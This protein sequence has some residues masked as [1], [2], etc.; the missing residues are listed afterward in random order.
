MKDKEIERLNTLKEFENN[1]Y[2][3]GLKYIAGIDEAGRGPLAGP[4]V[5]GIAIMEP[6]SFIEGI[7]DSKKI[8][9]KK[10]ELLY[11]KITSE[12]VDWA[13]GI[14]D[15]KEIDEI[16]ILN[17]TKKALHELVARIERRFGLGHGLEALRHGGRRPQRIQPGKINLHRSSVPSETGHTAR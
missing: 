3:T 11:E 9:E 5:V 14:V 7:N 2:K 10:R 16:N 13:V 4:V 12:A 8:A 17:A 6:N 1:L 15:Q